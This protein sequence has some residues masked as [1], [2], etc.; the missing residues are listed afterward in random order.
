MSPTAATTSYPK[1]KGTSPT[2][3]TG[4]AVRESSAEC[5]VTVG[6]TSQDWINAAKVAS[7]LNPQEDSND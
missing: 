1:A 2:R 3:G 7:A 4:T 6:M 5:R